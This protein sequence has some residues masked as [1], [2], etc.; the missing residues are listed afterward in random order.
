MKKVVMLAGILVVSGYMH[1]MENDAAN[2]DGK[3]CG[4][5]GGISEIK[6][7]AASK[8]IIKQLTGKPKVYT[9]D[10][11]SFRFWEGSRGFGRLV[12]YAKNNNGITL[13]RS[14]IEESKE[15]F[16]TRISPHFD[17]SECSGIKK[18]VAPKQIIKQPTRKLKVHSIEV[19]VFDVCG[20]W[21]KKL[22]YYA[23]DSNGFSLCRSGIEESE[24]E[25][26]AR[27]SPHFDMS[28]YNDDQ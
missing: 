28:E 11:G 12:Y 8:Q 18:S 21:L 23:K 16:F 19:G 13:C 14:G 3:G 22:V 9:I 24:E 2:S 20:E 1:G 5:G 17:M 6:E 26:F 27:I 25:F 10:L 15:E 7:G 4:N